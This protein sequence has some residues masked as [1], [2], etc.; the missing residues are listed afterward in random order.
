MYDSVQRFVS[1]I[2]LRSCFPAAPSFSLHLQ[3]AFP[4]ARPPSTPSTAPTRV[5]FV[6]S[7]QH[8][9]ALPRE[10]ALLP[11]IHPPISVIIEFALRLGYRARG[12]GEARRERERGAIVDVSYLKLRGEEYI[13][14]RE[15]LWNIEASGRVLYLSLFV[16]AI[17]LDGS[18]GTQRGLRKATL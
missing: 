7:P 5:R 6:F 11:T 14:D 4:A 9:F 2:P 16:A 13:K 17:R 12:T 1:P 15:R 8:F 10:I 3:P 18:T